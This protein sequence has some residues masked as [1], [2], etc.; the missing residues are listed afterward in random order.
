MAPRGD[1]LSYLTQLRDGRSVIV[2]AGFVT[3]RTE[4]LSPTSTAATTIFSSWR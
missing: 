2:E 4:A 3:S 1:E